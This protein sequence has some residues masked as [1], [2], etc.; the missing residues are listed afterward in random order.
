MSLRTICLGLVAALGLGQASAAATIVTHDLKLRYE[1]TRFNDARVYQR[2]SDLVLFE[3][4]IGKKD[5]DWGFEGLFSN[6]PIGAIVQFSATVL[7]PDNPKDIGWSDDVGGM[8]NGG[9]TY[10]CMLGDV[11]C[12]ASITVI[13]GDDFSLGYDDK[14]GIIKNGNS[15]EY[16]LW[17]RA[18]NTDYS[19]DIWREY[20]NQSAYFTV[21]PAP[22]PLPASIAL[23]PVGIG[24]LAMLRRRRRLP[25]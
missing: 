2:S 7:Y 25:G 23:V 12:S 21:L 16:W 11:L 4:D 3:G 14:S 17:G 9:S 1:G 15:L 6:L 8:S 18:I 22:V 19:K 10:S 20:E 24:A 13:S 5:Y